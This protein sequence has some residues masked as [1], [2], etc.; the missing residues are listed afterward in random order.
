VASLE[1]LK[2]Q[3]QLDEIGRSLPPAGR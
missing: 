1:H 3:Q 2:L